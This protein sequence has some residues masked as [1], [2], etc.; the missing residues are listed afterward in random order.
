[1]E[2]IISTSILESSNSTF[3]FDNI[4]FQKGKNYIK[5]TQ[6]INDK[7]T[8]T[9]ININPDLLEKFIDILSSMQNEKHQPEQN[10]YPLSTEQINELIKNYLKGVD[11]KSLKIIYNKPI[12]YLENIL[13]ENNIEIVNNEI[14]KNRKRRK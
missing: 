8:S 6:I 2:N 7:K 10:N 9:E 5:I 13:K 3:I 4:E 11:L 14:P 12:H 1:M